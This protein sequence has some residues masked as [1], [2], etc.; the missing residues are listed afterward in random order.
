MLKNSQRG[1][2]KFVILAVIAVVVG[3]TSLFFY[4][5]K[6]PAQQSIVESKKIVVEE[7][8]F[9]QTA[10]IVLATTT[11]PE[12]STVRGKATTE[13]ITEQT[14]SIP[15]P[16]KIP[17]PPPP[18]SIVKPTIQVEPLVVIQPTL[19]AEPTLMVETSEQPKQTLLIGSARLV[20]FTVI[21][22]TAKETDINVTSLEIERKGM[23]SDLIFV[24]VGVLNHGLEKKLNANHQYV[25]RKPFTIKAG[26]MEEITLYGNITDKDTLASYEGQSPSLALIKVNIDSKTQA[27]ILG[28]LPILGTAHIVNSS[29]TIGS[30]TLSNSGFDPGINKNIYINDTGIIFSA[31]RGLIGGSEVI[32][33][34]FFGFTQNGSAS[35]LNISN[36]QICIVYKSE[37]QC[38]PAD[39]DS[40]GKYYSSEFGGGIKI[41]KGESFDVYI[42][43]D[44]LPSGVNRTIDFDITTSYDILG[45]G[46][47]YNNYL[48]SQGGELDGTQPEGSFST[49]EYP[50]Y[51]GYA[52]SIVPGSFSS[53]R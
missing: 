41:G 48:Y 13:V 12:L 40:V 9:N 38:Y 1:F 5:Q 42:K 19:P 52:H 17:P 50:F 29:L 43:G 34:Q 33:L 37:T 36:V 14:V 31:I 11:V 4:E 26:E 28:D 20:P 39:V 32:D 51:N 25:M 3:A 16:K 47:S 30:M 46:Q 27:K 8:S 18:Q 44:A 21:N 22:L 45:L 10:D 7:R 2:V 6:K 24:E 15:P 49:T 53:G 35:F 23:G